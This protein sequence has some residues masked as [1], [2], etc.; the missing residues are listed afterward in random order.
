MQGAVKGRRGQDKKTRWEN[1]I[2]E[3]TG[4]VFAKSKRALENRKMEEISREVICGA[5][6]TLAV[7]GLMMMMVMMMMMMCYIQQVK[8]S[9]C[10]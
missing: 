5:P 8:G 10:S 4:L 6:T 1:N 7:K 9:P 2:R 3:W